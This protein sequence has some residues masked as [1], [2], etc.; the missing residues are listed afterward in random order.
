MAKPKFTTYPRKW[1][2]D[3]ARTS[4]LNARRRLIYTRSCDPQA[5]DALVEANRDIAQ[6]R[7]HL[8]SIG[9][10]SPKGHSNR[11]R[12]LWELVSKVDKQVSEADKRV[13]R[14]LIRK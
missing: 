2:E 7:V 13:R 5:V 10:H 3:F 8:S 6:A 9:I 11:T 12:R 1:H 14:C 4:A